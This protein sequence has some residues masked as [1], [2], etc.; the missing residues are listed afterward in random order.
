MQKIT[1]HL[2]YDTQAKEAAEMYV[3]A[4]GQGSK[5]THVN[6]L[7]DTPS[8]KVEMVSF[9]L[10]GFE[11]AAISAG[12]LFKLNPSISFLVACASAEEVNALHAKLSPG[13]KE[14]MELGAYPFSERYA[15]IEDKYGL[16]WQLIYVKENKYKQKI[17]PT[18]MF[19]GKN[20]GKAEEAMNVYAKIF[21]ASNI[22]PIMRYEEGESMDKPGTIKHGLFEL[23]G[24]GFA[25]MDSAYEHAFAF[26]EA[27]S[28]MVSCDTQ[29]EIDYFWSKLSAVPEAEQC[30]WLKDQY[31]VSWQIVPS[32][33]EEY[34]SGN[35]QEKI[36]RVTQAFLKMKKFDIAELEKAAKGS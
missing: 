24:Q 31:G 13:G 28:L 6:T 27:V 34:L 23:A 11:F 9:E 12:P 20:C 22:G 10:C 3:A 1:P 26:N 16:S 33:M 15:W 19:V 17:T 2:W 30:G 8:G 36:A 25:I 18:L 35:D 29:K 21:D 32:M 14:L 4:F 5:I 7:D